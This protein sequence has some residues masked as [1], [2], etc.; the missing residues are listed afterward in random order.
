MAS[1]EN[2]LIPSYAI[3]LMIAK[4]FSVKQFP[5]LEMRTKS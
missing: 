2:A 4:L 3:N 5:H 1:E